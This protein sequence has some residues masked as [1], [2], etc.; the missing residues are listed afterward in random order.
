MLTKLD[1]I[2]C[3][4]TCLTITMISLV[5]IPSM[6]RLCCRISQFS[7]MGLSQVAVRRGY[8]GIF[9]LSRRLCPYLPLSHRGGEIKFMKNKEPPKNKT[10]HQPFLANFWIFLLQKCI[11]S[12]LLMPHKKVSGAATG[13]L[14][15][16]LLNT[17]LVCTHLMHFSCWIQ[18]AMKTSFWNVLKI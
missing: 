6:H 4:K 2:G 16:N 10:K 3:D 17:R 9:P 11:L 15:N 1:W 8:G 7:T 5:V 14:T 12:Y 18:M 13:N